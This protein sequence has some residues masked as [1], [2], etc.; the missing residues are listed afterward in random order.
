MTYHGDGQRAW[1]NVA[2]YFV[3][4]VRVDAETI[5]GAGGREPDVGLGRQV[6][7]V[8]ARKRYQSSFF[9]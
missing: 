5:E 9:Q 6:V 2:N 3:E 1:S 7:R 4:L 8:A